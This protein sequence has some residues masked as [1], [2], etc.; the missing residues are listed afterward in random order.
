MLIK[1]NNRLLHICEPLYSLCKILDFF[2]ITTRQSIL[3]TVVGVSL[4]NH[5]TT[6]IESGFGCI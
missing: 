5:L 6:L 3:D 4:K 2:F 1:L